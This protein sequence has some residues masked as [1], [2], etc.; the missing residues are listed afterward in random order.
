[1]TGINVWENLYRI[2]CFAYFHAEIAKAALSLH[3][4][5]KSQCDLTMQHQTPA[6]FFPQQR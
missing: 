4:D 3:P 5:L 2:P 1:M 6:G